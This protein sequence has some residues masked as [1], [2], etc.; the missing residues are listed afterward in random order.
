MERYN[1]LNLRQSSNL[2]LALADAFTNHTV[3]LG[4]VIGIASV[5]SVK[6]VAATHADWVWLDAEHTP[7][8]PTLLAD[9]V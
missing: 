8:S 2:R 6:V 3:L 4:A 7:Y 1:A 9:M 5:A